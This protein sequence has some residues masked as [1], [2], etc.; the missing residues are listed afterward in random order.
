[1]S[2]EGP[3]LS[4]ITALIALVLVVGLILLGSFYPFK[5]R[6]PSDGIGPLATLIASWNARLPRGDFLVNIFFYAPLGVVGIHVPPPNVSLV[7]RLAMTLAFGAA[8]T[9]GCELLQYYAGRQTSI[10]DVA[11]NVIGTL[12]G[13]IAARKL[14]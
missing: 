2:Q 10:F 3:H 13:V 9:I 7:R 1:L 11:A 5:Y 8:L 4:R 6:P 12:L 14:A